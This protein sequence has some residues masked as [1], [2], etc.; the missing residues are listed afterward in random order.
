MLTTSFSRRRPRAMIRQFAKGMLTTLSIDS[1]DSVIVIHRT[2]KRRSTAKRRHLRRQAKIRERRGIS[3][4]MLTILSRT[5]TTAT[6]PQRRSIRTRRSPW[7]RPEKH[8]ATISREGSS[9]VS[10]RIFTICGKLRESLS[11]NMKFHAA[12]ANEDPCTTLSIPRHYSTRTMSEMSMPPSLGPIPTQVSIEAP[13]ARTGCSSVGSNPMGCQA[14]NP[15]FV[16][17]GRGRG[18][19]GKDSAKVDS[20]VTVNSCEITFKVSPN[21]PFEDW[22]GGAVSNASR[23]SCI[24]TRGVLKVFLENVIRDTIVYTEH[25]RRKTVSVQMFSMPLN[26][27]AHPST[28]DFRA[29]RVTKMI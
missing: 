1:N 5:T 18:K 20:N 24:E 3:K 9:S 19:E 21:Q 14:C 13:Q 25:A 6:K 29:R 22:L 28:A 4:T 17:I 26:G 2:E 23:D 12:L 7:P 27:G 11:C 8:G 16:P 15:A 10:T